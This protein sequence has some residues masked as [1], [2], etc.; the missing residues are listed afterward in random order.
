[1][2]LENLK[3]DA[4]KRMHAYFQSVGKT[5]SDAVTVADLIYMVDLEAAGETAPASAASAATV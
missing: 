1:M 5:A 3:S 4:A 2:D